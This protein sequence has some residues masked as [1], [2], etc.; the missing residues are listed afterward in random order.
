MAVTFSPLQTQTH[1]D[2]VL[3]DTVFVISATGLTLFGLTID[4]TAN[5]AATYVKVYFTNAAVTLG[6]TDPDF[7]LRVPASKRRDFVLGDGIGIPATGVSMNF[8]AVTAGGTAGTTA[9]T[10]SV[11]ADIFTS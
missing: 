2:R 1:R 5:T 3:D 6:T 7:V 10:N 9:P 11:V 4:N 8:A